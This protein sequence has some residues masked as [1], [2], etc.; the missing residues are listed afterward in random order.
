MA[1]AGEEHGRLHALDLLRF[2]AALAVVLF[3]YSGKWGADAASPLL[4]TPAREA[5][6]YGYLGV[7]LF[8]MISGFVIPMS[9]AGIGTRRFLAARFLRLWPAFLICCSLTALA[10]LAEP[11]GAPLTCIR[12]LA[13]LTMAPALLRQE[14]LDAVYWTLLIELKFYAWMA[15]LLGL[16]WAGRLRVWVALWLGLAAIDLLVVRLPLAET[17]FVTPWAPHFAAGA[18]VWAARRDGLRATDVL[19]YAAC[20]ALAC[21]L[22]ER[23]AVSATARLGEYLSGGIAAALVAALFVGFPALVRW[24]RVRSGGAWARASIL[25]GAIS[26]PLY[27]IHNEIGLRV[28]LALGGTGGAWRQ[29]TALVATAAGA[30][31]LAYLVWRYAERPLR[32]ALARAGARVSASREP[33]PS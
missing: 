11:R 3:H 33:H 27:L 25:L 14:A 26:Y 6:K 29:G 18:L 32:A 13:N 10:L 22:A 16:D 17:L 20:A 5:L 31:C 21:W 30:V 8:F 19:L 23:E 24:L 1:G 12:Y 9:M 4:H 28:L 15:L 7:Q 2:V